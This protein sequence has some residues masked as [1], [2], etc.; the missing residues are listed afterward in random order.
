MKYKTAFRLA[1]RAIGVFLIAESMPQLVA[2]LGSVIQ[3]VFA[4]ASSAIPPG[5]GWYLV[6]SAGGEVARLSIG[7]Y[8]FFR[9]EWIVNRAIPSNRPYCHECGYELRGL[10][11]EGACPE[12]GT[13]FRLGA[14]SSS[15]EGV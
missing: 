7:F 4:S 3:S 5:F 6:G 10:P 9:G 13:A 14:G 12:C 2:F 15:I 1:L 11:A 8:L